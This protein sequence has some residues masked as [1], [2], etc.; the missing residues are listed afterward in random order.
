MSR[1]LGKIADFWD[2]LPLLG[3][4]VVVGLLFDLLVAIPA[5]LLYGGA[6]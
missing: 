3:R 5:V 6:R 1:F 2:D 4:I